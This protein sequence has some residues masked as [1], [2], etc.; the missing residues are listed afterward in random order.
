MYSKNKPRK[1]YQCKYP[2]R[3]AAGIYLQHP[4]Q[5]VDAFIFNVLYAWLDFFTPACRTGRQSAR[6]IRR[7]A[8]MWLPQ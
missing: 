6:M 1:Y 2:Y 5:A 3:S 7:V 4:P 8:K